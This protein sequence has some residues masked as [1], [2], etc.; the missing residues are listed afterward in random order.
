MVGE[1]NFCHTAVSARG[2]F[3]LLILS[4]NVSGLLFAAFV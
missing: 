3:I 4:M 2:I 1:A